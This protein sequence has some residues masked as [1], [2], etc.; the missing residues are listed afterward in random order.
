[1]KTY[2]SIFTS[3]PPC[4]ASFD[5]TSVDETRDCIEDEKA[6]CFGNKTPRYQARA[7]DRLCVRR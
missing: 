4:P 5:V 1:M 6:D 3:E 2:N 7:D